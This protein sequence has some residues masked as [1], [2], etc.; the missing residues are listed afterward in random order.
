MSVDS[1][2]WTCM[3][4]ES[5]ISFVCLQLWFKK[6]KENNNHY[7]IFTHFNSWNWLLFSVFTANF[8]ARAAYQAAALPKVSEGRRRVT[9]PP[10]CALTLLFCFFFPFRLH[11]WRLKL[12]LHWDLWPMLSKEIKEKKNG[13]QVVWL[14][15]CLFVCCFAWVVLLWKLK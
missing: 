13:K 5:S 3:F 8:P 4:V 9:C 7:C 11:W 12:S 2:I 1:N 6:K 15:K 14:L 10:C